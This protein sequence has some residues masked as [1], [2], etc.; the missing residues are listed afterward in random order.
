MAWHKHHPDEV[1]GAATAQSVADAER[2]LLRRAIVEHVA[3]LIAQAG[4][5]ADWRVSG[6]AI[7]PGGCGGFT[8]L[9]PLDEF[10]KAT[11]LHRCGVSDG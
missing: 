6:A 5:P 7:C 2:R 10:V 3:P 4:S 9:G 1:P 11:A 8:F